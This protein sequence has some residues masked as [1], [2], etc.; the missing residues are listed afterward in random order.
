MNALPRGDARQGA[1]LIWL[2][3]VTLLFACAI[4]LRWNALQS[5]KKRTPDERVYASYAAAVVRSGPGAI[6]TL[7][8]NYN[9]TKR[10]WIYPPPTRVGYICLVAAVE[11]I[12][13]ASGEKCRRF[14]VFRF[15]SSNVSS[16]GGHRLAILQS[17]GSPL[18][19]RV[20]G[21]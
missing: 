8:K 3:A 7:V 16:H 11:K 2:G 14:V 19:S 21:R 4:T 20:S 1:T 12:S 13:G 6:G 5:I 17:L 10:Q 15:Q 9:E 18:R